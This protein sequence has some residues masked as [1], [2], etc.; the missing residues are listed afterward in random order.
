MKLKRWITF[1]TPARNDSGKRDVTF[2][3]IPKYYKYP[4]NIKL[5]N[6][7]RVMYK[8]HDVQIFLSSMY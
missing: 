5:H 3:L 2:T 8:K 6:V 7:T 1:L 4:T